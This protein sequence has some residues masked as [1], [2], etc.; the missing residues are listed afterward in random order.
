MGIFQ[1]CFVRIHLFLMSDII[2][3]SHVERRKRIVLFPGATDNDKSP[4]SNSVQQWV[5]LCCFWAIS[6]EWPP[7]FMNKW[8]PFYF[9]WVNYFL[10][11]LSPDFAPSQASGRTWDHRGAWPDETFHQSIYLC[12]SY[13]RGCGTIFPP[14]QNQSQNLPKRSYLDWTLLSLPL[15]LV[16]KSLL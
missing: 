5:F 13:K 15:G 9:C 16:C 11:S 4:V 2:F 14:S 12:I 1:L 7:H 6:P 10:C 3:M 8:C